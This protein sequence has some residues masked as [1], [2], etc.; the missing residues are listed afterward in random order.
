MARLITKDK[1]HNKREE[2]DKERRKIVEEIQ[3]NIL[4]LNDEAETLQ[5]ELEKE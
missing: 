1:Y 3:L 2:T 4:K 5:N